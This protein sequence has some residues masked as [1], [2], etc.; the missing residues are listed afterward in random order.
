VE[1]L[2]E[3]RIAVM[4]AGGVGKSALTI[5][6]VNSK[7]I[8]HYDPTIEDSYRKVIEVD[9]VTW[10][11]EVVDTAGTEQFS[12]MRDLYMNSCEGFLIVYSVISPATF[13]EA[14]NIR[15]QA[16]RV[17]DRDDFPMVLIGNKCDLNEQRAISTVEGQEMAQKWNCSFLETSVKN[18]FHVQDCFDN[19]VR[20]INKLKNIGIKKKSRCSI[21]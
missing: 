12:A 16:C 21:L 15:E 1:M 7:F 5:Y 14:C 4:G 17:K 18:N 3:T 6:F 11:L 9:G 19:L 20:Q 8:E 13:Y 2:Y 10:V